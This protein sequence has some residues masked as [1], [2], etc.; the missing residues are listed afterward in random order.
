M[1]Y[2]YPDRPRS[3][4]KRRAVS[5]L[6]CV[7]ALVLARVPTAWASASQQATRI[8]ARVPSGT[9]EERARWIYQTARTTRDAHVARLLMEEIAGDAS[10]PW[11]LEAWLWKVRYAMAA[12]DTSAAAREL[13][14]MA[15]RIP[16]AM[17]RPEA[18]YW[19][20]LAGQIVP[21]SELP[22]DPGVPPWN[23]L[24]R[25][26]AMDPEELG[27]REVREALKL[28]GAVRRWGL[29]C[30]WLWRLA[31]SQHPWTRDAASAIVAAPGLC[32]AASP[33][34]EDLVSLLRDTGPQDEEP[35][36]A[37]TED[38]GR[39]AADITP[40]RFAVQVGAFE[41]ETSA[42]ALV[43]EL[44]S[45]G[46]PAYLG[47]PPP[48]EEPTLFRVRIGPCE[49]LPAAESLGISLAR[50]LMVAYQIIEERPA[51]ASSS[52]PERP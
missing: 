17:Q 35:P 4:G 20:V 39:P 47:P 15:A 8:L 32:L 42:R 46:F 43:R 34:R 7:T 49:S 31:R 24:A 22:Q 12:G 23:L 48:G 38:A 45:H 29:L 9:T 18:L 33:E 11:A 26:A 16:Q 14:D 36:V 21:P 51:P 44:S 6:L 37:P 10:G 25:V 2:I 30:P 1:Q 3:R 13:R 52:P 41:N 27:E 50:A 28:E 19:G 40:R 5:L